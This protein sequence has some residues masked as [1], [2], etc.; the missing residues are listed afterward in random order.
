[1][2]K[3]VVISSGGRRVYIDIMDSAMG[4]ADGPEME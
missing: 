3:K 2:E 1:M 4:W